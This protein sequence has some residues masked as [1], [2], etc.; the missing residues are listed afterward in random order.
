MRT[1]RALTIASAIAVML[2]SIAVAQNG[3]QFKDA[4][5]WGIKAGGLA[6][7][8]S[9]QSYRPAGMIGV[10]WLIT[11]THGGLYVSGSESF[12]NRQA[13]MLRDATAGLDSGYRV[14]DLKNMRKLDVALMGFPGEHLRFHP[15]V[16]AGFTL[17][18]VAS[19]APRGPF[20]NTDQANNA[21]LVVQQQRTAV[22][23][24]FIAGGQ[25]R[26]TK[27]SVFGQA[28]VAASNENF[29][30]Y[31]GKPFNFGFEVGLRY[32]FGSSIDRD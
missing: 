20:G 26:M 6:L 10:D 31:N 4:W 7:A 19:A 18:E 1:I 3:R 29:L 21:A 2:P 23:P 17:G 9:A 22:A 5:F 14:I 16:G 24:L 15:Y 11:R 28:T 27:F 8:D 25:Y 13:L 12:F 32:N 30:L